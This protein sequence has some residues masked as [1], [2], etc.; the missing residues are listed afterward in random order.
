M[1]ARD[2]IPA[3]VRKLAREACEAFGTSRTFVP[4][5][6][7][8]ARAILADRSSRPAPHE[9]ERDRAA[10][11]ERI[12]E[13]ERDRIYELSCRPYA[14]GGYSSVQEWLE[15]TPVVGGVM[16]PADRAALR[17]SPHKEGSENG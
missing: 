1:T 13:D 11:E 14:E 15:D 4:L 5:E 3:D 9:A 10:E 6:V 12:R 8:V 7:F 17:S 16:I 2:D